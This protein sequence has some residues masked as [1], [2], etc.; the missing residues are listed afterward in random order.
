MRPIEPTITAQLS[1]VDIH[2][3]LDAPEERS[4]KLIEPHLPYRSPP[5]AGRLPQE[6]LATSTSSVYAVLD[7]QEDTPPELR[8]LGGDRDPQRMT[9]SFEALVPDRSDPTSFSRRKEHHFVFCDRVARGR[10]ARGLLS[11]EQRHPSVLDREPC[12]LRPSPERPVSH[13]FAMACDEGVAVS[14]LETIIRRVHG[15]R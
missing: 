11:C 14:P 9:S 10:A 2:A 4:R 3:V 6:I 7:A 12:A 15:K 8:D 5:T 1:Y 13:N